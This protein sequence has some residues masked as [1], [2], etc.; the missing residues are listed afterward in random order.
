MV[1]NG[2]CLADTM[3]V[4]TDSTQAR[5]HNTVDNIEDWDGEVPHQDIRME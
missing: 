4:D 3:W 5:T 1:L 2:S